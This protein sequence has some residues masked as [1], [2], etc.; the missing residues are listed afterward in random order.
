MWLLLLQGAF[1]PK[2]AIYTH[3]AINDII[4]EARM[5]GIRVVPEFDTPGLFPL[6]VASSSININQFF[7]LQRVG[8]RYK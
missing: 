5:R 7:S 8:F 4:E 2:T 6:F 3:D 1:D